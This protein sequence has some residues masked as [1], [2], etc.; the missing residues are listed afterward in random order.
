MSS[1]SLLSSAFRSA[2]GEATLP[3]ARKA[4]SNRATRRAEA[5]G[6]P[7]PSEKV[8]HNRTQQLRGQRERD[9]AEGIRLQGL[10]YDS[11]GFRPKDK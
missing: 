5:K 9:D 2:A 6:L 3:L 10:G 7:F 11:F 8:E 1:L 4:P